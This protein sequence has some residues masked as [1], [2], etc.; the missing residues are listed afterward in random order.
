MRTISIHTDGGSR[1]NPG[2]AAIGVFIEDENKTLAKIGKKIG[3]TTNN[4]AE[5]TAVLEALSW[6]L[7]NREKVKGSKINFFIDSQLIYSQII[8]V[9]KI[10]N[11]NLRKI[12][13]EIRKKEAEIKSQINYNNI[14]REKNKKADT[15]V[16]MALD[17]IL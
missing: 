16:N 7:E 5:Y 17:N 13:F 6:V 11:E 14:P 10:K 3:E 4:I 2:P 8:G 1:G 15:L 9:Y 12:L